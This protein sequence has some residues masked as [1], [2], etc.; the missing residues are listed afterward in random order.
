VFYAAVELRDHP[1]LVDKP[2]AV[3]KTNTNTSLRLTKKKVGGTG[4]LVTANYV[5]RKFGVR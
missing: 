4:M 5:A 1:H 2:F 3:R